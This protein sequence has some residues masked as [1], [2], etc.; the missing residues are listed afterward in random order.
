MNISCQKIRHKITTLILL[1]GAITLSAQYVPVEEVISGETLIIPVTSLGG[2]P[3]GFAN[4]GAVIKHFMGGTSFEMHYT[5]NSNYLGLDTLSINYWTSPGNISHALYYINVVA[6]QVKASSDYAVTDE[7]VAVEVNVLSNDSGSEGSLELVSIPVVSDG[8]SFIIP[9]STI[10]F[11]PDPGFIGFASLN[12]IVCDPIGTCDVGTVTISVTDDTPLTGNDSV[13]VTTLVN[14]PVSLPLSHLGYEIVDDPTDGEI[15][16]ISG[17]VIEYSPNT[18]FVG[19]DDFLLKKLYNGVNYYRHF[20]VDVKQHQNTNQVAFDDY[21]FTAVNTVLDINVT[22]NDLGNHVIKTFT[23]PDA[24]EGSVVKSSAHTLEFTPATDFVGT[25][26][27]T[28]RINLGP[29]KFETAT[30]FVTVDDQEPQDEPFELY[31]NKNTTLILYY[32]APLDYT[33]FTIANNPNHGQLEYID[34]DTTITIGSQSIDVSNVML[35]HPDI[36]YVGDDEFEIDYCVTVN[37]ACYLTKILVHVLDVGDEMCAADDCVWPGDTN[38]DGIA[39]MLDILFLG[40]GIGEYGAAR[41]NP[42]V[43][44]YGQFADEWGKSFAFTED[45]KH[46]DSDGNGEVDTDDLDALDDFY[47]RTHHIHPEINPF[48]KKD[49][50]ILVPTFTPPLKVGDL[51]TFDIYLGESGN[52]AIN[53]YGITYSFGYDPSFVDESSINID[54]KENSWLLTNNNSPALTL[55]KNLDLLNRVEVGLT[56]T[57]G[58][59]VSGAGTVASLDFII[60]DDLDVRLENGKLS[61]KINLENIIG[62]DANNQYFRLPDYETEV[63]IQIG[64]DNVKNNDE[65]LIVFPNPTQ[66]YLSVHLNGED[67]INHLQVHNLAGQQI[68]DSGS[69]EWERAQLSVNDYSSGLYIL[70]ATLS[71]GTVL[72]KKF[73]VTK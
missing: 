35:Y 39:N 28:Y 29:G 73:E 70:T 31:T 44:W 66:D 4:H 16:F 48:E 62:L 46:L 61:F 36:D 11:Q 50:I 68:F 55:V 52:E 14:T 72:N 45:M 22:N 59:S 63:E 37:S 1:F 9:D 8:F 41:T 23:Q 57:N 5:P 60:E 43:E 18:D 65:Q 6:S 12:Y 17:G 10:Y 42:T 25:A 7:G 30:V 20:F 54:F 2:S 58:Y 64:G 69:V 38:N 47:N 13:Y 32:D 51:V 27:F 24:S 34:G 19:A 53:M 33:E 15:S 71:D 67:F 40:K 49:P 3:S 56:R 21:A 26:E